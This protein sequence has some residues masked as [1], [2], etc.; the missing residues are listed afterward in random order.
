MARVYL[1]EDTS[2]HRPV[3]IKVLDSRHADDDQFVERFAREARAAAGL[4]H[5]N[6]VSIYDRGSAGGA[7]YIVMEYV[8]GRT[9]KDVIDQEGPLAP[10]RSVD[11]VL[12]LLAGLRQAHQRGVI[13]R[14]VKPH[15]VIVQPDG[16]L[17]V[18]DFGIARAQGRGD[19]T[20]AG[21][22]VGT[23]QYLAPEQARGL[24][25]GPPS[26]LY[27][28]GVVL[29]EML[30]GKVP[31]TGASSVAIAMKQVQEEPVPPS[32]LN[33]SV[34]ADLEKIVLRA[35][36][37]DP[38]K[39]YQTADQMGRD[40]DRWRKGEEIAPATAATS[41]TMAIPRVSDTG[42]TRVERPLEPVATRFPP[43]AYR[44]PAHVPPGPYDDDGGDDPEGSGNGRLWGLIALIVLLIAG[45]AVALVISGAFSSGGGTSS[46]T[47]SS[48]TLT[49]S[50]RTTATT[51]AVTTVAF[52]DGVIGQ[53][54]AAAKAALVASGLKAGAQ[55]EGTSA[56]VAA[57]SVI[58]AA[59]GGADVQPGAEV[60]RG[61]TVDLVVSTGGAPV[62]AAALLASVKGKTPAEASALIEAAGLKVAA[63]DPAQVFSDEVDSGSVVDFTPATGLK[64]GDTVALEVSKGSDKVDVPEVSGTRSEIQRTIRAA[65]LRSDVQTISSTQPTGT[66]LSVSPSSGTSVARGSTVTVVVSSGPARVTV[67]AVVGL[68]EA[69]AKAKLTADGLTYNTDQQQTSDPG[70]IGIVISQ[71]PPPGGK[72][73]KGDPVT[74]V[75]GTAAPDVPATTTGATTGT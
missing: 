50:S 65:G 29:Y 7:Y 26:D 59:T 54:L 32:R 12:Q 60:N 44:E 33:P 6:I 8:E 10:R 49:S 3:A 1:A 73:S 64:A 43:P 42:V 53:P 63:G 31:F 56:T 48:S 75:V 40:L 5:P 38:D 35:L 41:A 18:M 13:H 28:T 11:L 14:D 21:S 61:S 47:P 37:K 16:R 67:P 71:D 72:A 15:N 34:P 70:Q 27:A 58:S 30:T 23:A 2:L 57:G 62:D 20:E 52:P 9:L 74:I 45:I 51:T 55:T 22:I 24:P 17:K 19:M 4:N 36:V 69:D 46:T 25:V 68:S 66:I 39:R